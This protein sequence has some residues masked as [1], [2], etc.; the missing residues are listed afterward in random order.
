MA[1]TTP[2][3]RTFR[4]VSS[5]LG[6]E[7]GRVR[8]FG[9]DPQ[10]AADVAAVSRF[11]FCD[12]P[13]SYLEPLLVKYATDHG[14]AVRFATEVTSVTQVPGGS[15]VSVRD[16]IS[17]IEY[18]IHTKYLLGADGGR[19]IVAK[20]LG[21]QFVREPSFGAACNILVEAD[22]RGRLE[23]REAMLHWIMNPARKSGLRIGG[24]VP[25]M[26]MVR[27]HDLWLIVTFAPGVTGDPYAG[28][29]VDD[30]ELRDFVGEIIG[31][32][33]VEFNILR[34]D[35]WGVR[36]VVA[37]RFDVPGP[38]AAGSAKE[39]PPSVFLLGDAAHR[40]PPTYGL[41]SNTCIQ[42]AYNLA[43][44]LAFVARGLA[45]PRLLST[46]SAERQPVGAAIVSESNAAM[47]TNLGFWTALGA[48][49]DPMPTPAEG[50]RALAELSESS[51]AGTKRREVTDAGME[52]VKRET[53]GLGICYN[54]WYVSDAVVL[55]D[56]PGPRREVNGDP[57]V[58]TQITTY[59]GSRLPH[60]RL[61]KEG[62][63]H[64]GKEISTQDVAGHGHFT[65]FVLHGG[66]AWR[67]AADSIASKTGIPLQ[68]FG[69]GAGLDYRDVWREWRKRCEID[70]D[71]CVL[72]RPDR[73]V[74]WR[75]KGMV[76]G[77]E[78]KLMGV[79]D[80]VLARDQL[81]GAVVHGGN[82]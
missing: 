23:G 40:H 2:S 74:A 4:W 18:I 46:Y 17:G 9:G 31:D 1:V 45:G 34:F 54:Q 57:M 49:G 61:E 27:P 10:A 65:L 32:D 69:I 79:L 41:G 82:V 71:G 20:S 21:V 39:T 59:P 33:A 63:T 22:L 11:D 70:E 42:D 26:R 15:S 66:Q 81:A 6:T 37:E 35:A 24:A 77:C 60:A 38:P 5:V 67:D 80:K 8:G 72:V 43:W 47:R 19:S 44:K 55:D 12:L 48:L 64:V 50:L 51:E 3:F 76:D 58:V 14:F 56:E 62:A 28:M 13:Q 36:E 78:T 29:S 25:V 52:S 73:F 68:A 16:S 53:H 75:S 30:P 7:Y